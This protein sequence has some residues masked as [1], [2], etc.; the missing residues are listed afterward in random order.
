M[1]N[2]LIRILSFLI[3]LFFYSI[4]KCSIAHTV[5]IPTK[6][7]ANAIKNS[8]LIFGQ[9]PFVANQFFFITKSL[10]N[11]VFHGHKN[12]TEPKTKPS[13]SAMCDRETF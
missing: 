4:C 2:L 11:T 1:G 9:M 6:I 7:I 12:N 13:M 10:H 8:V 3:F 5:A